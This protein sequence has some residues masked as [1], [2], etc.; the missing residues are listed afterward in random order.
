M[1]EQETIGVVGTG[2]MGAPMA[3]NLAQAGF[4]V[5]EPAVAGRGLRLRVD[6][7]ALEQAAA[8]DGDGD[9]SPETHGASPRVR[10]WIIVQPRTGAHCAGKRSGVA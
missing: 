8:H 3:R 7:I 5:V 4:E 6:A 9:E 10:D 2:I 1:S